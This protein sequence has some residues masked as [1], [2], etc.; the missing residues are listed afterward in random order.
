MDVFTT[1][2]EIILQLYDMSHQLNCDYETRTIR[3][4]YLLLNWITNVV[5]A[6]L[7]Y[8]CVYAIGRLSSWPSQFLEGVP[9]PVLEILWILGLLFLCRPY[10]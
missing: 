3:Q 5:S 8:Y 6:G 4:G 9:E 10:V 7:T 2:F 1:Q